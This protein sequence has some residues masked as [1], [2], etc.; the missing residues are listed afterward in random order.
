MWFFEGILPLVAITTVL[1]ATVT[2]AIVIIV[3]GLKKRRMEIEAYKAA[4]DKGLPVPE[5][6]VMAKSPIGTLKAAMIW[7]AVGIGFCLIMIAEEDISALAVGSIPIL[8]GIALIIS[9]VIEKKEQEKEKAEGT[10]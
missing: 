7:I 8:V 10:Q 5:L 1:A 3:A 4:I 9:Y 2:I 6:K